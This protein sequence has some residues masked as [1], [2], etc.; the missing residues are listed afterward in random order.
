MALDVITH[1]VT[2][3]VGGGIFGVIKVG[4]DYFVSYKK[5][6]IT[7]IHEIELEKIRSENKINEFNAALKIEEEKTKQAEFQVDIAKQETSQEEQRTFGIQAQAEADIVSEQEK[8]K[9]V[10]MQSVLSASTVAFINTGSAIRDFFA[11]I[12]VISRAW[13]LFVLT[14]YVLILNFWIFWRMKDSLN[15]ETLTIL[16]QQNILTLA[17]V[18][19]FVGTINYF[20]IDRGGG[21]M[22]DRFSGISTPNQKKK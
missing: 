15:I 14:T 9:Q 21:K 5:Q 8:T 19:A 11:N 10:F 18:D 7:N 12:T 17:I 20:I 16:L 4:L 22:L 2:S 6:K 1:L 3:S 13:L